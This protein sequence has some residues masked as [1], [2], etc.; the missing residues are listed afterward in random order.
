[1]RLLVVLCVLTILLAA[2]RD[3]AEI[4]SRSAPTPTPTQPCA[5]E[6]GAVPKEGA[7]DGDVDGDGVSDTVTLLV[8]ET[9]APGCKAFV[10]VDTATEDLLSPITDE[11]IDFTLGFPALNVLAEID[12]RP[13]R[14]VVV[15]VTAG[16]STSFAGVF[17]AADGFL[18]RV[19]L[20][21]DALPYGDL[22]PYGGS[23]GH[24]EGSDCAPRG[25]VVVSV[26]TP[27]GK[28]YRLER[29]F[30]MFSGANL[31]L[32][33]TERRRIDIKDLQ[34]YPEF[35]GPPFASCD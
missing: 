30:L 25:G 32:E 35:A 4:V 17:S 20:V 19:R 16:A 15:D 7:L 14:E 21:G 12:G 18:Q 1:M 8:N 11:N 27:Q 26:A 9:G 6:T 29:S 33:D 31:N 2:C 23:V 24:L 3:D 28:R 34:Q 5:G 13:G 10:V 22:F